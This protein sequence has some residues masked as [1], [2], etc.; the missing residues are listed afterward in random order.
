MFDI[1]EILD[2]TDAA[3]TVVD[4]GAASMGPNSD[5]YYELSARPNVRI[6]G[7]EPNAEACAKR[8]AEA[9]P[10]HRY[11]PYFIADGARRRFHMCQNPLTSSLFEPNHALLDRFQ[12]LAL[13]VTGVIDVDTIRLDDV[14]EITGCDLLKLDIQGAELLAINGAPKIL[15]DAM[16]V[17]TEVE[18]IPMYKDQPLFGDI[19]V[20]LRQM[21]FLLH[22]FQGI[23]GR[24]MK[25]IVV[26]NNPFSPLSQIVFAEAAVYVKD[27]MQF[28]RYAPDKLVNLACILH[29]IYK[30]YDLCAQALGAADRKF[31][32]R[33]QNRYLDRL[34]ARKI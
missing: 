4:V 2:D 9:R 18:F 32:T 33:Y 5:P 1:Y 21:G 17:H 22:K 14:P 11:L 27:F 20:R 34:T 12:S 8:N 10:G 6:I 25:P 16:V 29:A 23:F 15:S 7:F 31:G 24:Q 28:D 13:P 26:Q 30:S 19:D 3:L